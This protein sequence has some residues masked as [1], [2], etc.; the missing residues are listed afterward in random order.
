MKHMACNIVYSYPTPDNTGRPE[1]D[2]QSSPKLWT[3]WP[4][5]ASPVLVAVLA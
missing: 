3:G 4:R 1:Q 5:S 2:S